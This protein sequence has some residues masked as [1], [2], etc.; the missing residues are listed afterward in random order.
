MTF[1]GGF[2]ILIKGYF[3]EHQPLKRHPPKTMSVYKLF[4][5][6]QV[7]FGFSRERWGSV[8]TLKTLL[9]QKADGIHKMTNKLG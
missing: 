9:T 5:R 4:Q 6:S 2:K 7:F 3:N 8:P 1:T